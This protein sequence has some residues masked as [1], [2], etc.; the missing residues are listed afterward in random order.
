MLSNHRVH[1]ILFIIVILNTVGFAKFQQIQEGSPDC[2]NLFMAAISKNSDQLLSLLNRQN[3]KE[4][5]SCF[6]MFKR[7]MFFIDIIFEKYGMDNKMPF[8][9]L[10]HLLEN[11]H[12]GKIEIDHNI[13]AHITN[14]TMFTKLHHDHQHQHIP[15]EHGHEDE[16]GHDHNTPDEHD[17]MTQ[18]KHNHQIEAT[19][20]HEKD[21]NDNQGNG[22][23]HDINHEH[24][25]GHRHRR[26]LGLA[27]VNGNM[28]DSTKK[29][30]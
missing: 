29:V 17:H 8:E 26:E 24:E 1:A 18:G 3:S 10:E 30:C 25:A 23:K 28:T 11:V 19:D 16:D 13:T 21:A 12:L 5:V 27:L 20:S 7:S 6:E 4:L 22:D 2:K 15:K 14:T 9:A